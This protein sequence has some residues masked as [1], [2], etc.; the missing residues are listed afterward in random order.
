MKPE[1]TRGST[2]GVP[3][4]AWSADASTLYTFVSQLSWRKVMGESRDGHEDIEPTALGFTPLPPPFP[5]DPAHTS[6]VLLMWDPS[7]L[8]V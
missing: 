4:T 6:P 2:A 5:R 3:S 7:Y 8:P 1:L